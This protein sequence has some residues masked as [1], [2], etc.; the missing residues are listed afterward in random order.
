[1]KYLTFVAILFVFISSSC[2]TKTELSV[3][4]RKDIGQLE[5]DYVTGWFAS[6]QQKEVL[7]VFEKEA[8]FIPHHGDKAVVGTN[9]IRDFFWP[10]GIGGI[11]HDFNH[12]PDTI[13]GTNQLAWVRGRF[14]VR[15]SWIVDEDTTTTFNE[16]N[17]V[18]IA[19][20][21]PDDQWKIATFIFNDP[22]AQV[23]D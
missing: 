18:F 10:D 3:K 17:Y 9:D 14:D 23:E 16:G 13:E 4:D 8:V 19:R 15:Y 6:D 2:S 21:Q 11:V 12:Y 5:D 22:V 20:K 7:S 1:M